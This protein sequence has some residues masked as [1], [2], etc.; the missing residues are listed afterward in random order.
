MDS[1]NL[2]FYDLIIDIESFN[3]LKENGWKIEKSQEE[4]INMNFLKKKIQVN[5][6]KNLKIQKKN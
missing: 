6:K 3:D 5:Q 2:G 4:V 1:D